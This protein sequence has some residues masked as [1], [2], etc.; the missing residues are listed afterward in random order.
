MLVGFDGAYDTIDKYKKYLKQI[1]IGAVAFQF[2]SMIIKAFCSRFI[3]GM[4]EGKV[5]NENLGK[6]LESLGTRFTQWINSKYTRMKYGNDSFIGKILNGTISMAKKLKQHPALAIGITF[7]VISLLIILSGIIDISSN[8]KQAAQKSTA[9]VFRHPINT[10]KNFGH[11]L[12]N[13]FD[14]SKQ[15][16][17][18]LLCVGF[19]VSGAF[20]IAKGLRK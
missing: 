18:F 12:V 4:M 5:G 9:S 15:D 13:A 16:P 10:I 14:Q 7:V 8:A 1:L 20:L 3:T 11:I 19:F 2:T 17:D 6:N